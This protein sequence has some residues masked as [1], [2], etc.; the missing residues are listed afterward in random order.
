MNTKPTN[1]TQSSNKSFIVLKKLET[2]SNNVS[3]YYVESD[4]LKDGN[5][6]FWHHKLDHDS[7]DV[8]RHI[9]YLS[10]LL[11]G[12]NLNSTVFVVLQN[13]TKIHLIKVILKP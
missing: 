11:N 7:F 3:N 12:E 4:D 13:N 8:L 9:L 10:L 6:R 1:N 2:F 5:L